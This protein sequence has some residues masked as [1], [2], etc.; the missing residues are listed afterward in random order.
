MNN[1]QDN[2]LV[3]FLQREGFTEAEIMTAIRTA[4]SLSHMVEMLDLR[5]PAMPHRLHPVIRIPKA[6][7]DFFSA[8][9]ALELS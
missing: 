3:A 5:H 6:Q 9:R 1:L 7:D 2:P 4:D 8:K